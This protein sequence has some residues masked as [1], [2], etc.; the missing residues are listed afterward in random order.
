ME[1]K[2]TP[3]TREKSD[4]RVWRFFVLEFIF[5]RFWFILFLRDQQQEII[6]ESQRNRN[7]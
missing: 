6:S 5:A 4:H 2:E 3:R 1:I 7:E